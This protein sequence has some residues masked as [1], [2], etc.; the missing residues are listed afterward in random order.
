STTEVS[1]VASKIG[2][3]PKGTV[4]ALTACPLRPRCLPPRAHGS[5]PWPSSG[6]SRSAAAD[7]LLPI[8]LLHL[9]S[10]RGMLTAWPWSVLGADEAGDGIGGFGEF[11]FGCW[12]IGLS[13]T[14]DAVAHMV[15]E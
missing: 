14:D 8:E 11:F 6:K 5:I 4:G 2:L 7:L 10:E 15:I 1:D 9:G 12:P 3:L 13:C